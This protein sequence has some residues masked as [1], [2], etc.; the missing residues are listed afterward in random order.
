MRRCVCALASVAGG[1]CRIDAECGIISDILTGVQPDM[2]AYVVVEDRRKAIQYAMDK[3][4][5]NDIIVLAGKGHED[6]QEIKGV[7]HP[8]DERVIIADIKKELGM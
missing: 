6:Y 5:K 2:G 4:E 8:M 1:V 7:K 3:A